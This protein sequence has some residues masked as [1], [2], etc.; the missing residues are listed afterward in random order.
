VE[1]AVLEPDGG[2]PGSL[3]AREDRHH[4]CS[5]LWVEQL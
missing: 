4:V 5:A 3:G 2:E 1:L